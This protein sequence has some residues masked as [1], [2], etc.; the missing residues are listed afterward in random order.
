[1]LQK[2]KKHEQSFQKTKW[3]SRRDGLMNPTM[4]SWNQCR[5]TKMIAMFWAGRNMWNFASCLWIF[6]SVM[7]WSKTGFGAQKWGLNDDPPIFHN[8]LQDFR[9]FIDPSVQRTAARLPRF[10]ITLSTALFAIAMFLPQGGGFDFQ[11]ECPTNLSFLSKLVCLPKGSWFGD[12]RLILRRWMG[13]NHQKQFPMDD[14]SHPC[15]LT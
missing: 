10:L 14:L 2:Q 5:V 9:W 11:F 4:D 12:F 13:W 8:F 6:P 7:L 1:M 15:S 3:H